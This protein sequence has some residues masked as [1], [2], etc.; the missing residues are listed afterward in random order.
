M[1]LFQEFNFIGGETILQKKFEKKKKEG[2]KERIF[3]KQ[4]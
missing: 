4:S 3:E 1:V 2:K